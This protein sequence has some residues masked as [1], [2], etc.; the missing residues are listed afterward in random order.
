MRPLKGRLVTKSTTSRPIRRVGRPLFMSERTRW[1]GR[2]D[3]C[4]G[5]SDYLMVAER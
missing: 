5:A 4:R 2:T 1:D 3:R